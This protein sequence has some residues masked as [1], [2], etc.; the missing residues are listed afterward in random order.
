[1][2]D[3]SRALSNSAI[4]TFP[5]DSNLTLFV[6]SFQVPS[7]TL[8]TTQIPLPQKSHWQVP[9]IHSTVEIFTVMF[10]ADENFK[11]YFYI[12]DWMHKCRYATDL[13]TV[14]K[15]GVITIL[16]NHKMPIINL[17][18]RYCWPSSLGELDLDVSTADPVIPF[19]SFTCA[20]YSYQYIN[21][22][23]KGEI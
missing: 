4:M 8:G 20:E 12:L 3:I 17:E 21:E 22:N 13:T 15:T 19:V 11:N 16:N 10:F 7:I 5:E 23:T 1:M 6:K 14:M 18:L 9:S 2:K